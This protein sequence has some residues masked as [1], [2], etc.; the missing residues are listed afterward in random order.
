M[1]LAEIVIRS[2]KKDDIL[3]YKSI[4]CFINEEIEKI[5]KRINTKR[6]II[7]WLVVHWIWPG[8]EYSAIQYRGIR[9]GIFSCRIENRRNFSK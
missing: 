5:N 1:P 6:V 8:C 3:N 7:T 9:M 2:V 4:S